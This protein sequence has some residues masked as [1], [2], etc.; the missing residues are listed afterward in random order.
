MAEKKRVEW[1]DQLRG[2]AMFF[3][4][5]GHI[6]AISDD[7][8]L[9]IYAFHMPLFFMISGATF[10]PGK[11]DT[12]RACVIDKA[13]K[14]LVPYV[15][16]YIINIIFWW[17]NHR[18]LGSSD[19]TIPELLIGMLVSNQELAPMTSG[20]LWFLPVLFFV[21][22]LFDAIFLFAKKPKGIPVEASLILCLAVSVYLSMFYGKDTVL[23]WATVPMAVVFYYL[24]WAFMQH[25]D[26]IMNL[27]RGS[28]SENRS[29]RYT[30]FAFAFMALGIWAAFENGK[31]SMHRNDYNDI[32][33]M[34]VAAI[35]L[36]LALTM[37]MMRL[38][39][40]KLLD[41]AGKNSIIF[42]GFHIA[43]I[44]FLEAWPISEGFASSH[45]LMTAI[46]VFVAMVP[47]SL[48]V[49]KFCPFIVGKKYIKKAS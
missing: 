3:V 45:V 16:L 43:L 39:K 37:L 25:R 32:A 4:V 21:S 33:L 26:A 9:L 29:V 41:F 15:W 44:R 12:L 10:R 14:L 34:F 7:Q 47:V 19:T 36:S 8:K 23:H 38:P 6:S 1:L 35:C 40:I 27:I 11:Y 18:I 22:V 49:N 17:I 2:T 30:C 13:K 24:G 42:F 48:F 20:A 31:I 46:I 5:L 28:N